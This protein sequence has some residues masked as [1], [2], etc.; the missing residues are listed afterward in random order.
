MTSPESTRRPAPLS[1]AQTTTPGPTW[2]R[3]I[4]RRW[5]RPR[6]ERRYSRDST[7]RSTSRACRPTAWSMSFRRGRGWAH[8]Q[9]IRALLCVGH[10]WSVAVRGSHRVAGGGLGSDAAIY[11][12]VPAASVVEEV[13]GK[14]LLDLLSAEAGRCV[15]WLTRVVSRSPRSE[16]GRH[17]AVAAT[18]FQ[19]DRGRGAL[20]SPPSLPIARG[21]V[22]ETVASPPSFTTDGYS[23]RSR[24]CR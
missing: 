1:V 23:A 8:R 10:R 5:P 16:S 7:C 13:A 2:R 19:I 18:V 6:R 11:A 4:R 9:R 3:S 22:P 12:T 21:A 24:V 20:T 17:M 15:W 14:W